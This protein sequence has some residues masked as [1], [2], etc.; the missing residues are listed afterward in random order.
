MSYIYIKAIAKPKE[1]YSKWIPIDA[2]S[3]SISK[4]TLDYRAVK[5]A[6]SHPTVNYDMY[7]NL[8][9]IVVPYH[10]LSLSFNEYLTYIGDSSLPTKKGNI[11]LT[12]KTVIY[13]DGW[14]SGYTINKAKM[15]SHPSTI[16]PSEAC[17]DLLIAHPTQ[18]YST[19]FN[20]CLVTINGLL[21]RTS[22]SPYGVYIKDGASMTP[23]SNKTQIGMI[24]FQSISSISCSSIAYDMIFKVDEDTPLS[25]H[26]YLNIGRSTE[27]ITVA[28]SIGGYLHI[29]DNLYSVIGDGIIKI[30][31]TKYPLIQRHFESQS[32]IDLSSIPIDSYNQNKNL[33]KVSTF[34]TDDYIKALLTLSQSFLIFINN[35]DIYITKHLIEDS[36]LP[37]IFYHHN[38]PTLPLYLNRG[39]LKEY[40]AYEDDGI[41]VLSVDNDKTPYYQFE[42]S[43]KTMDEYITDHKVPS[44]P[45]IKDKPYLLEIASIS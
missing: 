7:L 18:D 40:I 23:I 24:S 16:W 4:L 17:T 43:S 11:D 20:H 30:D 28:I 34:Y 37:N 36:L 39:M 33:H 6:L 3:I 8:S 21:H 42:T 10:L 5:I 25:T 27:D 35:K 14:S 32:I 38:R 29:L 41:W 2:S 15:G 45:Y 9:D 31:F 1:K 22:L 44:K 13:K 26:T 19:Y 12:T